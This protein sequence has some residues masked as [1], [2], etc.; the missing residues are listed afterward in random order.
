M[1]IVSK[2]YIETNEVDIIEVVDQVT[3]SMGHLISHDSMI[4][5][6]LQYDIKCHSIKNIS[7]DRIEVYYRGSFG[8]ILKYVYQIHRTHEIE[9]ETDIDKTEEADGDDEVN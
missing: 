5:D 6:A 9:T 2:E 3:K 7:K 4:G 8:N 1:F